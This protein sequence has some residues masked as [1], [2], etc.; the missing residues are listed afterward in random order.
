MVGGDRETPADENVI[1]VV[2]PM[3]TMFRPGPPVQFLTLGVY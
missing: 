1:D 3:S 2:A